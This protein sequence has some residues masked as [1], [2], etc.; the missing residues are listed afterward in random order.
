MKNKKNKSFRYRSEKIVDMN[1]HDFMDM[2]DYGMN[3]E[4]I[5][6]ELGVTKGEVMKLKSEI[7]KEL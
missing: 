2:V 3:D 5:A 7:H 4:E 6:Y 1:F